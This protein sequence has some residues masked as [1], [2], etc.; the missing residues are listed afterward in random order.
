MFEQMNG[1]HR[2]FYRLNKKPAERDKVGYDEITLYTLPLG[3]LI[4]PHGIHVWLG[5]CIYPRTQ[6]WQSN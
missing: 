5:V 6:A 2:K 1:K 4:H 3:N